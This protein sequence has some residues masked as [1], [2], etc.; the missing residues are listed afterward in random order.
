MMVFAKDAP[1]ELRDILRH[2]ELK[3]SVDL[4]LKDKITNIKNIGNVIK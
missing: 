1:P 3:V 4:S 2:S